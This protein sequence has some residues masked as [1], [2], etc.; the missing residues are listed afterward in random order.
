MEKTI[1]RAFIL[2]LILVGISSNAQAVP[3]LQIGAPGGPGEGTYANYQPSLTNPSES[4][5]ALT[6]GSII[7]AAGA[8]GPNTTALGGDWEPLGHIPPE[9]GTYG[10]VLVASVPDGSALTGLTVGGNSPFL[11]STSNLF[12]PNNHAP[13]G[14]ADFMYFDIGSFGNGGTVPDFATETGSAPGEIKTLTI[15]GAS[16]FAW[17][18]FDVMAVE[19]TEHPGSIMSEVVFNPG[20][21]DVTLKPPTVPEPG[22]MLLL[23]SGLIGLWGFRRKSRK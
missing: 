17:V 7:Y 9:F 21:H 13:L 23:G 22:T 11:T 2:F 5:T 10:A 3:T 20:S 19:I 18:H 6:A 4:D 1:A 16:S 8:Y 15:G 12:F 14:T